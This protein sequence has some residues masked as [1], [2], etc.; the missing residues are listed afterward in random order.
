MQ[1]DFMQQRSPGRRIVL[2]AAIVGLHLALA[3]CGGH[4]DD[5]APVTPPVTPPV[6]QVDAFTAQVIT[7]AATAPDTTEGIAVDALVATAPEDTEPVAID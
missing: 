5:P 6:V 7:A 4:D 3:A 1:D 2:G